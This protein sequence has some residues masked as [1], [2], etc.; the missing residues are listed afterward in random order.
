M[1][2][3]SQVISGD[4]C[5]NVVAMCGASQFLNFLSDSVEQVGKSFIT[6]KISKFNQDKLNSMLHSGN[7]IRLRTKPLLNCHWWKHACP[8]YRYWPPIQ[9]TYRSKLAFP[10]V[11][12]NQSSHSADKETRSR[13][14]LKRV[15]STNYKSKFF[16][17]NRWTI[18][19]DKITTAFD[20]LAGLLS[21]LHWSNA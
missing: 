18:C 1:E 4:I 9:P 12:E 11:D 16:V 15:F 14:H 3:K 6:L 19:A 17:E 2:H 5:P 8:K 13:R 20:R 10:V 7:H 21:V